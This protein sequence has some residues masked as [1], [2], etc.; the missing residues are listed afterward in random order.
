MHLAY[1]ANLQALHSLVLRNK[2]FKYNITGLKTPT[3]RR[4]L[5]G[6]L[7]A[8]DLNSGRPRTN[9]ASDQSG[10]RTR[11]RWIASPT[12]WP[13]G[14]AAS[15][16]PAGL[17]FSSFSLLASYSPEIND[18]FKHLYVYLY[19]TVQTRDSKNPKK[20]LKQVNSY[21]QKSSKI[22]SVSLSK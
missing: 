13:V 2:W 12:R 11:D 19:C 17:F 18:N 5:V 3:G 6:Y 16:M 21:F 9:T 1:P 15:C 10:T 8:E 22:N 14:H 7:Q 20:N 4:Q